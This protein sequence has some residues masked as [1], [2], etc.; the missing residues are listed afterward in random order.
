MDPGRVQESIR[1]HREILTALGQRVADRFERAVLTHLEAGKG[2]Y[3][4]IFPVGAES[5]HGLGGGSMR[6][7]AA[8][9]SPAQGG[10]SGAA[11]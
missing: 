2:D 6:G 4:R 1:E 9:G 10:H 3:R 5:H 8:R 11:N 7:Q